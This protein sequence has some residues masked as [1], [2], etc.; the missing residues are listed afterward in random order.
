M[1]QERQELVSAIFERILAETCGPSPDAADVKMHE[2]LSY[3]DAVAEEPHFGRAAATVHIA[4]PPL[5]NHVQALQREPAQA[6][7]DY[8]SR[9]RRR[10]NTG[11]QLHPLV[12][13]HVSHFSQVPL[14]TIVKFWHSEHM[15]PV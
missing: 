6:T 13:P 15:L 2:W 5:S 10:P 12:L 1:A 3:F 9:R 8:Y 11:Y 7:G 14:R 4:Q